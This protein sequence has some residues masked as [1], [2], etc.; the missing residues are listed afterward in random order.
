MRKRLLPHN[1]TSDSAKRLALGLSIKR[2]RLVHTFYN[3]TSNDIVINW[4]NSRLP[5]HWVTQPKIINHP[6]NVAIAC[7]KLSTFDR[8]V[9]D[10][11]TPDYTTCTEVAQQWIDEGHK[12]YG[13]KTLTGHSGQG[14]I[15]FDQET[16]CT[17]YYCPLYTKATK[18]KDE[19]RVHVMT[20]KVIDFVLKRKRLGHE[21]G[22]R[23]I[24]NHSNG[25]VYAR[26][27]IV[28]PEAVKLNSIKAVQALG[29][30]F[31]AV[32]IGVR[33][34]KV[35]VYEVN[36]AP[37]LTGTTLLRYVEAIKREYLS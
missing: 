8:L 3:P 11:N 20:G 1:Q 7:N 32:D 34:D 22:T 4:G 17:P 10:V 5:E 14:I 13:R 36:T 18:A 15:I 23:G 37:G 16:I 21:G 28:L 2:L 35:F 9:S 26:D 30:D 33:E 19:Y 24:R 6:D 12:V 31:G 27:G 25:W 29:L